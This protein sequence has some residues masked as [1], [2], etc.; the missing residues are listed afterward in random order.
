MDQK[1]AN[2][3]GRKGVVLHY[4]VPA[5]FRPASATAG[6]PCQRYVCKY[7]MKLGLLPGPPHTPQ[8]RCGCLRRALRLL[9]YL[10][11]RRPRQRLNGRRL[12][13]WESDRVR[14]QLLR[15]Y[16]PGSSAN[17]MAEWCTYSR[18]RAVAWQHGES[19]L[20][21][22]LSLPFEVFV[23]TPGETSA[24]YTGK[25]RLQHRFT[26]SNAEIQLRE[27]RCRHSLRLHCFFACR[28]CGSCHLAGQGALFYV[29]A[30]RRPLV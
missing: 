1:L 18:R 27:M 3:P 24:T 21:E 26:P 8:T 23:C 13:R 17:T 22:H 14:H 12:L 6:R 10:I 15:A 20:R 7:V 28:D 4:P 19:S 16:T 2:T 11:R 29:A 5:A 25:L 9:R 30:S